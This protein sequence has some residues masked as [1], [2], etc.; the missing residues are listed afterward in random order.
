MHFVDNWTW[1]AIL[2]SIHIIG[3]IVGI[4]PAF[5]FGIIGAVTEKAPDGAVLSLL[6]ATRR[7]ERWLLVPVVRY[8]QWTTGVLLIFNRGLN[9]GFF[10]WRHAWLIT[11]I[12]LYIVLVLLGEFIFG[13]ALKKSFELAEQGR[14]KA[15]IDAIAARLAKIGPIFPLATLTIAILMIW[16]PGSGCG[17]L[18]RC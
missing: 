9:R 11:A 15:E 13:P 5:T 1:F 18:L 16:K 17:P 14:P 7:I 4:G 12:L 3:A 6:L 10:A 8:T 2:I